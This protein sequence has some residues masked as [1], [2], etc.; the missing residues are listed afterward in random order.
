[1]DHV[2]ID[3]PHGATVGVMGPNGAG[4]STLL[5]VLGGQVK[6]QAGTILL[7]GRC[8]DRV[9]AHRRFQDGLVRTFQLPRP[10]RRLTV[11][12]NLMLVA[13][14]RDP[15]DGS[16]RAD[17]LLRE[18]ELSALADRP[19]GELSGGQQKLLDLA[20]ALMAVPRML[21]LDEP[22]AGVT[23]HLIEVMSA[24]LDR[25]HGQGVTILIV[26]HHADFLA[27]H[28]DELVVLAEG[29]VLTR[30]RPDQVRRD[31]AVREALLGVD[32]G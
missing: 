17:R 4:K 14:L 19:A 25:L 26:E 29:A 10:F 15:A 2:T 18:L 5:S 1:M 6:H 11:R 21:L 23:P 31:P 12:E 13:P 3:V 30:G 9:P 16:A 8:I 20:R 28:C 27:R 22:C 24:T 32:F 7:A